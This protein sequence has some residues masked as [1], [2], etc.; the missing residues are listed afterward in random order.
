MVRSNL[1][2]VPLNGTDSDAYWK[3]TFDADLRRALVAH[4]DSHLLSQRN[5]YRLL[6]ESDFW[7]QRGYATLSQRKQRKAC[8]DL[9]NVAPLRF[10]RR[11]A[12]CRRITPIKELVGGNYGG[13]VCSFHQVC[14]PCWFYTPTNYGARKFEDT[15][16]RDIAVVDKPRAG[17]SPVC[18]GCA[19]RVPFHFSKAQV[20]FATYYKKVK[21]VA[22]P[23]EVIEID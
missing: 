1:P 22:P 9:W 5:T 11:C 20:C 8:T 16:T 4:S 13:A 6:R 15:K 23:P 12:R 10:D 17:K 14:R 3:N 18:F 2:D 7:K 21:P 19:Y